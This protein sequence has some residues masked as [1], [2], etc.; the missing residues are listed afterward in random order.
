M[1]KVDLR[2]VD[3]KNFRSILDL[4]KTLTDN[5]KKCVASNVYSIAEASLYPNNAFY[6]G[7]FVD[8]KAVGFI[9]VY[10]PR[11]D[12]VNEEEEYFFLWRFMIGRAYQHKK[13]GSLALDIIC[14]M[15]KDLGFD[16][17]QTSVGLVDEG[18]LPFYEKYGFV[19]TEKIVSD[20]LVLELIF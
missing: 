15:A 17:I 7:I 10:I 12:D 6:R 1:K 13:Y 20:E 3:E 16:R 4:H 18:P 8:D 2:E 11:K 9:M 19:S 14:D 5:Q